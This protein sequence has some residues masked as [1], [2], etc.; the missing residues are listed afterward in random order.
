MPL[1]SWLF[2]RDAESIW[3]ERH[4][5]CTM[6]IAGPG[7][8]REQREFINEDALQR[9]QVDVATRLTG[10]GWFLWAFD[11]DRRGTPD[12]RGTR[13]PSTERRRPA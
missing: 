10:E 4:D 5:R 11:R 7:P 8:R 1:A 2:V 13:R 3:I 6:L 9:Y 12:R